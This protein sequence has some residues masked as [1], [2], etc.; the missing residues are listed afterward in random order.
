M[1]KSQYND[2]QKN[3]KD[4]LFVDEQNNS[5]DHTKLNNFLDIFNLDKTI[6]TGTSENEKIKIFNQRKKEE[7]DKI[8][9][10]KD[11]SNKHFQ[12]NNSE[13]LLLLQQ[14]VNSAKYKK[15]SQ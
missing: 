13:N 11:F 10:I 3:I 14:K 6:Q 4:L 8:K 2:F 1:F 9:K 5:F 7:V 12:K 15:I